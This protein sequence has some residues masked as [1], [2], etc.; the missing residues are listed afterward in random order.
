MIARDAKPIG[1]V[2]PRK[3][4]DPQHIG[5]P[6]IITREQIKDGIYREPCHEAYEYDFC[7]GNFVLRS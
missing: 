1:H 4:I 3:P 6:R 2:P 7:S 5:R